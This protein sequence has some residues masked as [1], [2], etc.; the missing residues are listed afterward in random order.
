[1]TDVTLK[2][3]LEAGCHFGHQARRWHPSMKKY[4][5]GERDGV[6][7]FDLAQTKTGLDAAAA[8]AKATASQGG[9]I[10]YVGTKRQ[11]QKI[12]R[13]QAT[14]VGMP[15]MAQRW[16]AGML[17]NY[18]E[19]HKRLIRLDSLKAKRA[20][21]QLKKYTKKEQLLFDREI[22]KLEKFFGG[23]ANLAKKPQALFIVDSHKEDVA[24]REARKMGVPVIA[25]VDTNADPAGIEYVIPCNDDADKSIELI[26]TR[27]TDAIE[28]GQKNVSKN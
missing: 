4:I 27:I 5:Y 3:L 6:H 22:A 18:D 17:T 19:L 24:V 8:F 1:M 12:V 2:D 9:I 11:A 23:V 25:M 20:E 16:L 10:L 7:I 26:V 15:Y 21:G 14:R 13:E 28:E